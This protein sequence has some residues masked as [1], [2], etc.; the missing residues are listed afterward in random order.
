MDRV[1]GGE[2]SSML[3][4]VKDTKASWLEDFLIAMAPRDY[5]PF[6]PKGV[7]KIRL[8]DGE[9]GFVGPLPRKRFS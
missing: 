5:N 8:F 2:V 6:D 3:W 7:I 4:G 1:P 9:E